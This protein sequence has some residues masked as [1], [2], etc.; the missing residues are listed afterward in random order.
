MK[1]CTPSLVS[2]DELH[3]ALDSLVASE[4]VFQRGTPPDAVYRF[5]HALVQD[6]AHD[7]L[8]RNPRRPL[9]TQIAEALETHDPELMENQPEVFAQHYAEAGLVEKSITYWG[10]AGHRSIARSAMAEAAAQYEKALEQL[11][12][13]PDTP[14]RQWQELEFWSALG[15]V[16]RAVKGQAATESGQAYSRARQLW[17]Q[18]GSPSEFLRIPHALSLYHMNRGE[19]PLA[20]R[21]DEEILRLSH[22]R[23]D[24]AG[25]V[26]GH[27]SA[28]RNLMFAGRLAASRSH[29]EAGLALYDPDT[30]RLIVHQA[31]PI[32]LYPS[33]PSWGSSSFVSAFPIRHWPEASPRS[34]RP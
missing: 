22:R 6:A 33:K 12:L 21:L 15:T 20:L 34:L 27:H 16:L 5:K 11:A 7:G 26:L 14:K 18:L 4:L 28:G 17:E 9:H 3:S 10:K 32:P 1:Y 31:E 2:E 30:H 23:K 24:S 29:L 19:L 13:L 8:L 25:L